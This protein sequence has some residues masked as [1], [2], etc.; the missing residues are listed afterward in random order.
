MDEVNGIMG[1]ST[2]FTNENG[3]LFIEAVYNAGGLDA[4]KFGV[5]FKDVRRQSF[6]DIG[7][8]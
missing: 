7:A 8:Y 5:A 1:L 6:I 2:G 4:Q 3:P